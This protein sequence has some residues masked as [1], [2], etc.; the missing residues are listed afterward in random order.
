[1]CVNHKGLEK[2]GNNVKDC[3]K[4]LNEC[5]ENIQRFLLHFL[6]EFPPVGIGYTYDQLLNV[7]LGV[8]WAIGIEINTRGRKCV[9]LNV[10]IPYE[11][12]QNEA[13]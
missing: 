10:Y 7:R 12:P 4:M 6:D 5:G 11:C 2:D 1:M 9:F 3:L 13:E 8:N